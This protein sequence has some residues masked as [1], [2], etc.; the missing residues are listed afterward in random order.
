M[1]W[2]E[3][4]QLSPET[5]DQ[6]P[7]QLVVCRERNDLT[8]AGD[9]VVTTGDIH[10]RNLSDR[11]LTRGPKLGLNVHCASAHETF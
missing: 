9:H 11:L 3:R 10:A 2:S 1:P 4:Q 7:N 8:Q 5:S 6:Y